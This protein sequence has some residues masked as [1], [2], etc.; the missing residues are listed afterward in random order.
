MLVNYP[1]IFLEVLIST[2]QVFEYIMAKGYPFYKVEKF[3]QELAWR[4]YWQQIWIEK[5]HTYKF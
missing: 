4:D 2:K 5:R 3:I 1:L